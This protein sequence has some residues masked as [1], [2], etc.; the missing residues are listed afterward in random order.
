MLPFGVNC[1]LQF[2]G[3]GRKEIE[4]LLFCGFLF[5]CSNAIISGNIDRYSRPALLLENKNTI[6]TR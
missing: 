6:E 3:L 2:A 1:R 4:E 5:P